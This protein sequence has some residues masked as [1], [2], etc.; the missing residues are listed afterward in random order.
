MIIKYQTSENS[1]KMIE[2]DEIFLDRL[3]QI[4]LYRGDRVTTIKWS[5]KPHV[6]EKG[7]WVPLG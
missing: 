5:Q 3:G 4:N 7:T 6:L 2:A 1:F